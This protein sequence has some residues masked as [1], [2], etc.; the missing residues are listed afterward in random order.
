MDNRLDNIKKKLA[1]LP[2]KP[3]CYLMKDI[4]G[5]IIYVGKAKKLKNRVSS[6]FNGTKYGKTKMLVSNIY[7]FEY[8]VTGSEKEALLLEINLITGRF[9]QIRCQLSNSGHPLYG[10]KK[11]GSK[12][13][14]DYLE[15]PLE[16]YHLEFNHPTTKETLV[17]EKSYMI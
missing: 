6:Y 4:T 7:D 9:H 3:G 8:I 5:T 14:I 13:S 11:Y 12:Y 16:A 10:D 1:L 15:F 17:F 2:L